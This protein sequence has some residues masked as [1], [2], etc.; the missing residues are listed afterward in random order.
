VSDLLA[1]ARTP[2]LSGGQMLLIPVGSTEQHGPHLP[3]GMDTVIA[4][5]VTHRAADVM[6]EGGVDVLIAP[7]LAYGASGEHQH[8]A[9]TISI[10][11]D[12]LQH[13]L[14]ELMRSAG[15]WAGRCVFVNGHGGNVPAVV[16]A[17]CQLRVE[18]HDVGWTACVP[19]PQAD[20]VPI[21]SHAGRVETSL[22]LALAPDDVRLER[23]EP[24]ALEPLP[25]LLARMRLEGVASVS[26]NGVLG[27]PAGASAPEGRRLLW[28]MVTDVVSS[29]EA[30]APDG[31]GRLR[32]G[33]S[34][35]V[36]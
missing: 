10:G 32:P 9:G 36:A 5:A 21:D 34:M 22:A 23:A 4:E 1:R 24:G 3:L 15:S 33:R 7:A 14:V 26:P 12:A 2:E 30:W 27:D 8:F 19:S 20:G 35:V 13:V 16:A 25:A 28:S 17:V 11:R 6:R 31:Q 29:V 18:G